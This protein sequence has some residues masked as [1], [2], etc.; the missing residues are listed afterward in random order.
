[1]AVSKPKR[2]AGANEFDP[3]I[4]LALERILVEHD[5]A[6]L[7]SMRKDDAEG[8]SDGLNEL[9]QM[10][11]ENGATD[12]MDELREAHCNRWA[13]LWLLHPFS[14]GRVFKDALWSNKP[15]AGSIKAFFGLT[16]RDLE[17]LTRNLNEVASQLDI[18]NG[19][20]E[21]SSLLMMDRQLYPVRR[22]PRTLRLCAGLF[23]HAAQYFARS[24]HIYDNIAKARLTSY[25]LTKIEGGYV[26]PRRRMRREF[27]DEA[28]ATLISAVSGDKEC[29]YDSTAHRMW[30]QKHYA[31]LRTLDPDVEQRL[32]LHLETLRFPAKIVRS[33]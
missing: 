33:T 20:I 29:R 27:R 19:K 22:L 6:V 9:E 23:L 10:I 16:S 7:S 14:R 25:V 5:Y 32:Q 24:S 4:S 31:R 3:R 26:R 12:R 17:R 21:F 2:A 15:G 8:L 28:I 1:V 11:T 30:R 13:L 18:V